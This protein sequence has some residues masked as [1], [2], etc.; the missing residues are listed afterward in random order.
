[1][2]WVLIWVCPLTQKVFGISG[3]GFGKVYGFF[4]TT[5]ILV[6]VE[7]DGLVECMDFGGG[8]A[9]F[10]WMGVWPGRGFCPFPVVRPLLAGGPSPR[11][12]SPR[13]RAGA[14]S[15]VAAFGRGGLGLGAVCGWL[16][17]GHVSAASPE[18]WRWGSSLSGRLGGFCLDVFVT[19]VFP[20]RLPVGF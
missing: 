7:K 19:G 18:W 1:M 14:G 10:A 2:F 3:P 8:S 20:E 4:F 6:G 17:G 15:V 13:V 12:S 5:S 9:Y 16:G 11:S